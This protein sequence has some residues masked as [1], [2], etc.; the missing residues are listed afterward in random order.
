[1]LYIYSYIHARCA[2]CRIQIHEPILM[3]ERLRCHRAGLANVSERRS[4]TMF[5]PPN[6]NARLCSA[7]PEERS[8]D[9]KRLEGHSKKF[10]WKLEGTI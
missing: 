4:P 3:S 7:M 9:V 5:L 2:G 10:L 1:M 8:R 6:E